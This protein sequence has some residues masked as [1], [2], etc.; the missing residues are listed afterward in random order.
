MSNSVYPPLC[1]WWSSL[2]SVWNI[3]VEN[4]RKAAHFSFAVG[5]LTHAISGAADAQDQWTGRAVSWRLYGQASASSSSEQP[6]VSD[7]QAF[8]DDVLHNRVK[9]TPFGDFDALNAYNFFSKT[10]TARGASATAD[11]AMSAEADFGRL[12]AGWPFTGDS[13]VG[14]V[15]LG[16]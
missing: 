1:R 15:M 4:T 8:G 2:Q 16:F 11:L 10:A 12:H 14:M 9:Y 3:A 6:V 5:I 13:A 7:R